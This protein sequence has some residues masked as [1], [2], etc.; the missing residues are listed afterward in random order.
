MPTI[1]ELIRNAKKTEY[2]FGGAKVTVERRPRAVEKDAKTGREEYFAMRDSV[3]TRLRN[4]LRKLEEFQRFLK[5]QAKFPETRMK[6]YRK[7]IAKE[8]MWNTEL[9]RN[10]YAVIEFTRMG[11][12]AKDPEGSEKFFNDFFTGKQKFRNDYWTYW[13]KRHASKLKAKKDVEKHPEPACYD[14]AARSI[15]SKKPYHCP[16]CNQFVSRKT[17]Y[18]SRCKTKVSPR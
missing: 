18:C 16:N 8:L 13:N 2:T 11:P 7:M 5:R 9:L 14:T 17:N 10:M 6:S 4:E 15:E 3:W 1:A 12:N